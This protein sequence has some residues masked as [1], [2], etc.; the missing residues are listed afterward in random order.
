MVKRYNYFIYETWMFEYI[1]T[2]MASQ[3]IHI[4]DN[5]E[6]T[7]KALVETYKKLTM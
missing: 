5:V 2:A 3:H 1:E 4:Y 7:K 6:D